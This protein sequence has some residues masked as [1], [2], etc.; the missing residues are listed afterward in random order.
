MAFAFE[1]VDFDQPIRNVELR[2]GEPRLVAV[3]RTLHR[4]EREHDRAPT[5]RRQ[6]RRFAD[7]LLERGDVVTAP[8]AAGVSGYFRMNAPEEAIGKAS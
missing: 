5:F 7:V 1:D 2:Q 6:N 4:I 8:C 3:S